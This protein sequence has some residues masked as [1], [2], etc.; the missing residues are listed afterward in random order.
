MQIA[1][2]QKQFEQ[3]SVRVNEPLNEQV[4]RAVGI[5]QGAV[6]FQRAFTGAGIS[7]KQWF[8]VLCRACLTSCEA[9]PA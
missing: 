8:H 9:D 3:F 7:L 2:S 6:C 1:R 5:F 4:Q